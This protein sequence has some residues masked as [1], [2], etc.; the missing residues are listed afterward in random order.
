M[1]R[2]RACHIDDLGPGEIVAVDLGERVAV[3]N[4]EGTVYAF[5]DQCTHAEASLADGWLEG[6]EVVCPFHMGRFSV[7]TGAVTCLPAMAPLRTFPV[8]V[9][10]GDV[11]VEID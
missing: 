9:E 5:Q 2:R 6:D 10:D 3:C 7:R 11:F 8:S 4:L 1:T